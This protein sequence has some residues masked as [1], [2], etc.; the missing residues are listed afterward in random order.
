MAVETFYYDNR[1]VRNFGL[2]T[3]IWGMVG[4]LVGVIIAIQ[5]IKTCNSY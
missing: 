5:I 3:I 1:I 2:A 4:M